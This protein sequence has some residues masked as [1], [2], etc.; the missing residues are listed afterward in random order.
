MEAFVLFLNY[1]APKLQLNLPCYILSSMTY[2][3]LP[4]SLKLSLQLRE[5]RNKIY[6]FTCNN[7][8]FSL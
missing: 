7:I 4:F 3:I 5:F 8:D 6:Y 1:L 2:L